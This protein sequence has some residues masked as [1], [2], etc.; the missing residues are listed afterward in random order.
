ML[1]GAATLAEAIIARGIFKEMFGGQFLVSFMMTLIVGIMLLV[2]GIALWKLTA[3]GWWLAVIG[4]II[5]I[6][7][8]AYGLR[9]GGQEIESAVPSVVISLLIMGYL[10]TKRKYFF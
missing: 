5:G 3:W 7:N 10:V 6:G 8:S 4:L 1:G 9:T 2:V